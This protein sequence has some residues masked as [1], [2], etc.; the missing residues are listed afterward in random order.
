MTLFDAA[1]RTL[2]T[3]I[4]DVNIWGLCSNHTRRN[5]SANME[6]LEYDDRSHRSVLPHSAR[7]PCVSINTCLIH[8][9]AHY[10]WM[11]LIT[12]S[13]VYILGSADNFKECKIVD[14]IVFQC[15]YNFHSASGCRQRTQMDASWIWT[16]RLRACARSS[17]NVEYLYELTFNC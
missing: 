4:V 12:P 2:R 11:L 6:N 16:I 5:W 7:R 8:L 15:V 17:R 1:M 3:E 13:D 14:Y 9:H 10:C